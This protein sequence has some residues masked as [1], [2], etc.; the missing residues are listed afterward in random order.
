[1]CNL[2]KIYIGTSHS[3]SLGKNFFSTCIFAVIR[4]IN[5]AEQKPFWEISGVMSVFICQDMQKLQGRFPPNSVVFRLCATFRVTGHPWSRRLVLFGHPFSQVLSQEMAIA[6]GPSSHFWLVQY[7]DQWNNW[8]ASVRKLWLLLCFRELYNMVNKM[9]NLLRSQ[10]VK[11]G[12]RVAIY[13]P[14]SPMAVASMLACARIGAI[15]S[16]VFAGFSADSLA[17]RINDGES[18][19]LKLKFFFMIHV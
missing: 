5:Q 3:H 1:M 4:Q 13:L 7:L 19:R 10:G 15:H 2:K 9:A 12:D 18:L 17:D 16:V 11:K 8:S 6:K 14:K